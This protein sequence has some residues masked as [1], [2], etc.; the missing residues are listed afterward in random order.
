MAELVPT[1]EYANGSV[2]RIVSSGIF[3]STAAAEEDAAFAK[4]EGNWLDVG[5]DSEED[6]KSAF[7]SMADDSSRRQSILGRLG[8]GPKWT[9]YFRRRQAMPHAP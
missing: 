3:R 1:E 5:D 2:A 9:V 6:I 8:G 7:Q 4:E